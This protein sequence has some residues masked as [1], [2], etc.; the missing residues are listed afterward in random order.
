MSE[1]FCSKLRNDIDD[2]VTDRARVDFDVG[3]VISELAEKSLRDLAIRR[4]DDFAGAAIDHIERNLFSEKNV[5]EFLGELLSEFL[6]TLLVLVDDLLL[7]L[8][9]LRWINLLFAACAPGG[10]ANIHHDAGASRWDTEGSVLH[11]SSFLT[12]NRAEQALF[13]SQLRLAL[14]CN[15][16]DEDISRA[17]LL[18]RR[19]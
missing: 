19:G 13:R 5:R 18:L 15:F 6:V 2:L 9:L 8:L 17:E 16:S 7:L 11:V 3:I 10:N 12:E 4:D 1:N 14:R